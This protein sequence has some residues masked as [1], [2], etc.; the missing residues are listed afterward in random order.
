MK[1]HSI[2]FILLSVSAK[3]SQCPAPRRD[4]EKVDLRHQERCVIAASWCGGA[5]SLAA[6]RKPL[7]S[8]SGEKKHIEMVDIQVSVGCPLKQLWKEAVSI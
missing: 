1:H 5:D 4:V 6:C 7:T 8:Q 2:W 3:R